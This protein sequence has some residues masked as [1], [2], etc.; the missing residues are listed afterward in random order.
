MQPQ[1]NKRGIGADRHLSTEADTRGVASKEEARGWR[2]GRMTMLLIFPV[3][4]EHVG[5]IWNMD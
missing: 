1:S 5:V 4:L 2:E 3:S